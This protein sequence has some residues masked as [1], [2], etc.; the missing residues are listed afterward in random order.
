M[1][2]IFTNFS[3]RLITNSHEDYKAKGTLPHATRAYHWLSTLESL[4]KAKLFAFPHTQRTSDVVKSSS[5]LII[6]N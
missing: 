5:D 2:M 4:S 6:A 3:E 1:P